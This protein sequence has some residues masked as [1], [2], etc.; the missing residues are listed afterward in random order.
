MNGR[1]GAT[2]HLDG[3]TPVRSLQEGVGE[4]PLPEGNGFL[5][6]ARQPQP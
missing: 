3:F 1:R 6:K 5:G 2:E 4:L